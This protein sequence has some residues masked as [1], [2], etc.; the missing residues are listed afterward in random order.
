MNSKGR[1]HIGSI[2]PVG[3]PI[4]HRINQVIIKELIFATLAK[5]DP[6]ATKNTGVITAGLGF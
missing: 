4:P 1:N 6:A 3:M 5:L 2:K